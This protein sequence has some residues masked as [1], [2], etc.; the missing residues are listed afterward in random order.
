MSV[1][2]KAVKKSIAK[3]SKRLV[4]GNIKAAFNFKSGKSPKTLLAAMEKDFDSLATF[5]ASKANKR[6][7]KNYNNMKTSVVKNTPK[8]IAGV[9]AT[10]A[11]GYG[12]T[13]LK[14]RRDSVLKE[15]TK[16]ENSF[17]VA[18]KTFTD[19]K[20]GSAKR[21]VAAGYKYVYGAIRRVRGN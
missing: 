15:R 3:K 9:G 14:A 7:L 21:E 1:V 17:T 5:K 12:G 20:I 8:A 19:P 13:K 16:Q 10:A 6:G 2:S 11:T 4:A 18:G